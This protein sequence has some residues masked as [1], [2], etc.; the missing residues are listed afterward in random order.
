M[1]IQLNAHFRLESNKGK[2]IPLKNA[3]FVFISILMFCKRNI[4]SIA[5]QSYHSHC[6]V[7][8]FMEFIRTNSENWMKDEMTIE[9]NSMSYCIFIYEHKITYKSN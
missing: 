9:D 7:A 3:R 2:E 8:V 4:S 5:S 1:L 6:F